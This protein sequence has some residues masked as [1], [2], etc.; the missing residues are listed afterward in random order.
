MLSFTLSSSSVPT[1]PLSVTFLPSIERRVSLILDTCK[2]KNTCQANVGACMSLCVECVF[3]EYNDHAHEDDRQRRQV[4]QR[5]DDVSWCILLFIPLY[6]QPINT[7]TISSRPGRAPSPPPK[8]LS[9][10]FLSCS[11]R[12]SLISAVPPFLWT[13]VCRSRSHPPRVTQP[14]A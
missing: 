2:R 4:P 7:K 12:I 14:T 1:K 8:P 11:L 13:S 5:C 10:A 9:H 3:G 6:H